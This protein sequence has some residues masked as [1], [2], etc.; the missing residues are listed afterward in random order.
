MLLFSVLIKLFVSVLP[1]IVV[2]LL[3][4]VKSACVP[5]F[6]KWAYTS[7]VDKVVSVGAAQDILFCKK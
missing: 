3:A 1:A 6:Y 5:P 7:T 2:L 4:V